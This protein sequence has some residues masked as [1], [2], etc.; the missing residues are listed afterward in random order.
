MDE[1]QNKLRKILME[2]NT[3]L[4]WMMCGMKYNKWDNLKSLLMGGAKGSK[5]VITTRAKLVAEI[6]AQFQYS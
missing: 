4:C 2:R 5:V 1:L 6:T 3:Y